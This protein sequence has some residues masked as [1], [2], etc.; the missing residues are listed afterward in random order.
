M[1]CFIVK[2]TFDTGLDIRGLNS[3]VFENQS[4]H[5]EDFGHRNFQGCFGVVGVFFL[6]R[7]TYNYLDNVAR[8]LI[9]PEL[10]M[11]TIVLGRREYIIRRSSKKTKQLAKFLLS[12]ANE[13]LRH[14]TITKE[15]RAC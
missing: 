12:C 7:H 3:N 1:I 13:A 8:A 2:K 9:L 10:E 6:E 4:H 5:Q 11:T 15:T 14:V